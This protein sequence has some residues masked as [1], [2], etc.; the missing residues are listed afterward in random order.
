MLLL[1]TI[2]TNGLSSHGFVWPLEVGAVTRCPDPDPDPKRD[3]G[4]GL[5]GLP[6]GEGDGS[7]LDWSTDYK[8]LVFEANDAEVVLSP[9]KGRAYG[10]VT[11]RFVGDRKA[12]TDFLLANG[13]AGK[14]VVGV[15]CTA[16]DRGTATAGYE[17]TAT[18]GYRG[19]ATAGYR[20]TATAG[21]GG[22]ATVGDRG[23]A[24]AGYR[25]TATVGDRGIATVGDRGIATAGYE[26]TATAGYEGTAT[27]GEG[28]I[29]QIRHWVGKRFRI[30]TGYVGEA[31]IKANVKYR[32]VGETFTEDKG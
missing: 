11:I 2:A 16:G 3:C 17:G 12:A 28:G 26:G 20:G 8:W 25:G 32:L 10:Q 30:V 9:G 7:L 19:T 6:W 22:I 21:D 5:H 24:T 1:R 13:A 29:I 18:A 15:F 14:A 23:T 4:G 27:A 31:A